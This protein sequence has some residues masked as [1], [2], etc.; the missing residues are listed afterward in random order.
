[1]YFIGFYNLNFYTTIVLQNQSIPFFFVNVLFTWRSTEICVGT[2]IMFY[3]FS[4][5]VFNSMS[6]MFSRLARILLIHWQL[7]VMR[8][9]IS[10]ICLA[11]LM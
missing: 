10:S 3:V 5:F 9:G 1:M 4:L 8:N 7:V 6:I 11:C 2:T